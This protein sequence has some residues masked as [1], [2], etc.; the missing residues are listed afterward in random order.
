MEAKKHDKLMIF[1]V[2]LVSVTAMAASYGGNIVLPQKLTA[3]DGYDYYSLFAA[4]S[5]MGMMVGLPLVGV[6]SSRF[7]TKVITLTGMLGMFVMRVLITLTGSG[8]RRFS[9]RTLS[10][11]SDG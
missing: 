4:L 2:L 7:G 6:L 5:S 10:Y 9:G 1:A 11:R 8:G 3:I